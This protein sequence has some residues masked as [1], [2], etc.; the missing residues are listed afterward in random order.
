MSDVEKFDIFNLSYD[1][2][3]QTL[4]DRYVIEF[5]PKG[6]NF[7]EYKSGVTLNAAFRNVF[8]F[9]GY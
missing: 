3:F 1:W 8:N 7:S 6:A 9:L 2:K 5:R 4:T